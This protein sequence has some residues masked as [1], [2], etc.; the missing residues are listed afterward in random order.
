MNDLK[1]AIGE[2]LFHADVIIFGLTLL[3]LFGS[4]V[5]NFQI[6]I[7]R[8]VIMF[9]LEAAVCAYS[10]KLYNTSDED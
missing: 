10:I 9:L 4:A 3:L 6:N 5:F 1:R 7:A 2:A 8:V